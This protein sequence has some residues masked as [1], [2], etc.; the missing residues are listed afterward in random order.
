M[1]GFGLTHSL[2]DKHCICIYTP[3]LGYKS[4]NQNVVYYIFKKYSTLFE[5]YLKKKKET[6]LLA[7]SGNIYKI[8]LGNFKDSKL[9][10]WTPGVIRL[11]RSREALMRF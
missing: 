4:T 11:S 2:Y 7:K 3:N 1:I 9:S 10:L 6:R 5:N 8:I